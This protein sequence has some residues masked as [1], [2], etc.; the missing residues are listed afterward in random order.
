MRFFGEVLTDA[1][2]RLERE[3][4]RGNEA[5]ARALID[6]I[7][8]VKDCLGVTEPQGQTDVRRL[9]DACMVASEH[10]GTT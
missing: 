9:L 5:E 1:L 10:P 4:A 6:L 3:Q 2:V 8:G 7:R